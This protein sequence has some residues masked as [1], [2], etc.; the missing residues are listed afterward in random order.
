MDLVDITTW[1]D[2][3]VK[4]ITISQIFLDAPYKVQVR[5]FVPVEGDLLEEKWTTNGEV[6]TTKFPCYALSDMNATADFLVRFIDKNV[7]TYIKGAI[8]ESDALIWDTY[9]MA[10][11]HANAAKVS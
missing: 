9:W 1:A 8:G 2:D 5:R 10:F 7:G 6:R 4:T 3:E 11:R